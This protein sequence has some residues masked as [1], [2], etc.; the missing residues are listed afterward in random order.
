[1]H[2]IPSAGKWMA[3]GML[4]ALCSA[5]ARAQSQKVPAFETSSLDRNI[6]PC[7]DFDGFANAGW[8]KNNPIPGTES[9]WGAFNI[10]DKENKEVRLKSIIAEITQQTELKKGT[11]EQ[12]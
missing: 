6:Q 3:A 2:I 12:Q 1:M 9:R 8:K 11:E 10:L 7:A 4:I 5:G